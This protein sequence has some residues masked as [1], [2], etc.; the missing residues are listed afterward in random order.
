MA[1]LWFKNFL[2]RWLKNKIAFYRLFYNLFSSLY[3]LFIIFNI[4]DIELIIYKIEK[5]YSYLLLIP[6]LIGLIGIYYSSK[7]ISIKE[8]LGIEQIKRYINNTYTLSDLD[9][10]MTL[11][12][13]GPYKYSRHPIYFF[14]II[15]VLSI[16][17]MNLSRL[18]IVG[19]IILYFYI[20]SIYEERKLV[21][22]FGDEYR[23]YQKSVP[24]IIPKIKIHK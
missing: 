15:I 5:P 20:G 23:E 12:I 10:K 14:S 17:E 2:L 19:F 8:F 6:L 1:S 21:E 22:I 3:F 24:R 11:R 9:E 18:V 7:F 4:P 16:P 13:E